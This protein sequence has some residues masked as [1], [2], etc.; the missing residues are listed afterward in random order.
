[1]RLMLFDPQQLTLF[2]SVSGVVVR[3]ERRS[4]PLVSPGLFFLFLYSAGQQGQGSRSGVGIL[5]KRWMGV[6]G[7]V[8]GWW[9]RERASQSKPAEP[10]ARNHRRREVC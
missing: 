2:C 10:G 5:A 8:G 7:L 4:S 1:M 6:A 3:E 9:W